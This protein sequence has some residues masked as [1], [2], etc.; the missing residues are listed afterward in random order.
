[1][2]AIKLL[3]AIAMAVILGEGSAAAT[4]VNW[5]DWQSP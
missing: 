4:P 2:R 1:M 3:P 5:T